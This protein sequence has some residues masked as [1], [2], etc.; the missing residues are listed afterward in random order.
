MTFNS[1]SLCPR[2]GFLKGLAGMTIASALPSQN[3]FGASAPP[4]PIKPQRLQPGDMV[5]LITPASPAFEPATIREG[6]ETVQ[7]LGFRVKTGDHIAQKWGYLAGSDAHRLHDLHQMF[8][9]DEVRAII[10][11]RGGYGSMR[12]LPQINYDLIKKHPKVFVGYSDITA[13]NLAIYQQTGLITFHGPVAIS[14]FS[15]YTTEYFLKILMHPEPLGKI[16]RPKPDN[17]LRPTAYLNTIRPGRATGR[18]V[19]G[20]LTIL[21]ALLGTPFEV[22]TRN[23]IL[24]LEET[25]EEPYDVDRMLTQLLLAGKLERAAGIVFDKCPDCKPR[26]YK[27][28]F[29]NTFSVE[30]VVAERLQ[31]CSCPVLFGLALGH[32][33]DKPTLPLGITVTLDAD[34][35]VLIFDEAAVT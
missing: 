6:V 35:Q 2:R 28:A 20:N 29:S 31:H 26:D 9:D 30:E 33:A 25:G 18:L 17:P 32:E 23:A 7:S 12:L 21:T 34:Q 1:R 10:C 22:D 3:I 16:N 24:F 4:P 13:L 27:P 8:T 5:G 15:S 14:S 19:G 11:L